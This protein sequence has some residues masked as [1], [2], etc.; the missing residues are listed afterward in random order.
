MEGKVS[1]VTHAKGIKGNAYHSN[2][3]KER[4]KESNDKT[5]EKKNYEVK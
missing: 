4:K 2:K 1:T 3:S 5:K